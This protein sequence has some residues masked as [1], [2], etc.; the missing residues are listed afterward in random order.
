MVIMP[1]LSLRWVCSVFMLEPRLTCVVM[2]FQ[3]ALHPA[4]RSIIM[5]YL[6][7]YLPV[8]CWT[9]SLLRESLRGAKKDRL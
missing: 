4:E 3:S 9:A 7:S 2:L 6:V 1:S 8:P 5:V